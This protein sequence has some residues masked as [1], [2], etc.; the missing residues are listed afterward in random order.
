MNVRIYRENEMERQKVFM[1][2]RKRQDG[3]SGANRETRREK[4]QRERERSENKL[5]AWHMFV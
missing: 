4:I 3:R 5:C 2:V 1:C